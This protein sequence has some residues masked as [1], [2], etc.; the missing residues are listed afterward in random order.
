MT[1][2]TTRV[3]FSGWILIIIALVVPWRRFTDHTH[4]ARIDW[5]P[6]ID[7]PLRIRDIVVN[8][9]MYLPFG[10]WHRRS[11]APTLRRTLV[12]AIALSVVTECSQVFSHGRF[13]T[14][15]DVVCNAAGA[16]WGYL[17]AG[18]GAI[19]R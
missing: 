4:W 12:S 6:F 2:V 13:P 18:R 9:L 16:V 3:L 1:R 19:G 14:S 11:G 5:T 8:T 17:W 7:D 15:A 10:Y